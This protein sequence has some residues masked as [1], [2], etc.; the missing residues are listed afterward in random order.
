MMI[1]YKVYIPLIKN[2]KDF[3][4]SGRRNPGKHYKSEDGILTSNFGKSYENGFHTYLNFKDTKK[5]LTDKELIMCK[6]HI[7]DIRT[8]GKQSLI[9]KGNTAVAKNLRIVEVYKNGKWYPA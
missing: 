5:H 2:Y 8:I 1:G 4:R 3:C 7:W 6:V 9:D